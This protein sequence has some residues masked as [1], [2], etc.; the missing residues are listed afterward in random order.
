MS[1]E[2]LAA[3]GGVISEHVSHPMPAC[4]A[5]FAEDWVGYRD[6][7][8]APARH[9]GLPSPALTLIFTLDEPLSIAAHPDPAQ[10]AGEFVT[11]AG[12]L[13]TA[14]AVITHDG[15]QSGLQ[16]SLTPRGCRA[17]LGLPAGELAGIDVHGDEVLGRLA[18]VLAER[19]REAPGWPERFALL[20]AA[21]TERLAA[22][23][24]QP[25]ISD[26]VAYVWRMLRQ[27][28]G[29]AP[30][31]RLAA[32]TGWSERHLRSRFRTETGL[33]P[34]AAARVIRFDRARRRLQRRAL[35]GLALDLAGLAAACG[36]S[37]QAHLDREFAALAG[38]SP[39][40]LVEQEF[41]NVQASAS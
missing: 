35:T 15:R 13:H 10:P 23:A 2:A 28:G 20:E 36:Y 11:L 9:R 8:V 25:A 14:P 19:L 22:S 18:T 26:E 7:G 31:A 21:L 6:A 17:L 24:E 30:V 38:C 1:A 39:T 5:P 3:P 33:G 29:R 16:L 34:K 27:T 32:E 4:L 12:G 37:D 41:R 40:T